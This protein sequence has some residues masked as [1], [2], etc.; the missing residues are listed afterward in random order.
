MNDKK[1]WHVASTVL[2]LAALLN[3][4]LGLF[5]QAVTAWLSFGSAACG[6][7]AAA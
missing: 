6:V 5:S 4:K 3:R 1:S 2:A 7:I